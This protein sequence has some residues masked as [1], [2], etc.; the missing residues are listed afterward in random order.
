MT[1]QSQDCEGSMMD[2]E[3]VFKVTVATRKAMSEHG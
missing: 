1:T 3:V 2:L